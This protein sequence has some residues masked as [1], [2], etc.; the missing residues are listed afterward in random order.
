MQR[1]NH[2]NAHCLGLREDN[3]EAFTV[4]VARG[5]TRHTEHTRGTHCVTDHGTGLRPAEIA[6]DSQ[7]TRL[8]LK[9]WPLHAIADNDQAG[10][11]KSA[12]DLLHRLNQIRAS[13]F[14][15]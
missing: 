12:L 8:S 13:F 2:R 10:K 11:R 9:V 14:L 7:P 3:S 1:T 15:H 5:H 6:I 4:S